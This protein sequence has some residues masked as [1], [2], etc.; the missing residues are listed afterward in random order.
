MKSWTERSGQ[1]INTRK[2]QQGCGASSGNGW[3]R[4]VS[5]WWGDTL[6]NAFPSSRLITQRLGF[7][8]ET[9]GRSLRVRLPNRKKPEN[10]VWG[11]RRRQG[12]RALG[13][14]F[15]DIRGG[16]PGPHASAPPH[17]KAPGPGRDSRGHA[18]PDVPVAAWACRL[19][20]PGPAAPPGGR[21]TCSGTVLG[22]EG[23]AHSAR[24]W[25]ATLP[26]AWGAAGLLPS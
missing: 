22:W 6:R 12:Q 18:K 4:G 23:R 17:R 16:P 3:W 21:C 13:L 19:G 1:I 14:L 20:A 5:S 9:L 15:H 11:W 10:S 7:D 25:A 2:I 8:G 24:C 26:H